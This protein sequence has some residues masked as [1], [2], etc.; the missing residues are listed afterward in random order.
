M[1]LGRSRALGRGLF[2]GIALAA[3]VSSGCGSSTSAGTANGTDAAA[4]AQAV[5]DGGR[6]SADDSSATEGAAP[7]AASDGAGS[8][9][10]GSGA[11]M[12]SPSLSDG[13]DSGPVGFL[14]RQWFSSETQAFDLNAP[15]LVWY[16]GPLPIKYQ[17]ARQKDLAITAPGGAVATQITIDPT[18]TYQSILGTGISMEES[19]VANILKLSPAKRTE[20]LT[21][22]VDPVNGMGL[23]LFRVTMG[24]SDFTGRPWYTYDDLPLGQ[25][26]PNMAQFSIQKDID[27]GIVDVLKQ[28]LAINPNMKFFGSPWSPPAWMKASN[29]ILGGALL[30]DKVAALAKYFRKFVEAYR[31]QGIPIY[32]VTLQNE[33]QHDATNMPT[34]LV[35]A[36]QEALLVKAIKQEFAA[37]VLD[38]KT[39]VFDHNF[40]IGVA[41]AQ[42]IFSDPAALAATDGVAF[43]DYAGDPTAMTTLHDLHPDKDIFFTEKTLWGVVGVD[44]AAQYFRNW[45]RTYVSWLTMLDQNGLPNNGPNSQK[46]RRFIRSITYTGDEYYATPE[47]YLFGLYSKFVQA[48]AKRISSPYGSLATVTNVAF[49]NPDG[50]IAVVVINQTTSLQQ[51]ALLSEGN[52]IWA[53]LDGKTAATYVWRSG[54]G[55]STLAPVDPTK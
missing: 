54:L 25:Q 22:L 35:S 11:T 5:A 40:D 55:T 46:P 7:G 9:G 16:S 38:T 6:V 13:G 30:S 52:Q 53:A 27:Y 24:T 21:K 4:G 49:L 23:N 51:F 37:G 14:A 48:G 1:P 12:D 32:A 8:D 19:S 45:S 43:H 18:V 15:N 36:Q 28:M 10:S 41:Y 42:T 33:P 44:R 34:C 17:L 3:V 39:W 2:G 31:A 26:D 47:H 29:Q 50:T 20:L